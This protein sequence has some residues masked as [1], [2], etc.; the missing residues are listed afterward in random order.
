MK[1]LACLLLLFAPLLSLA[2]PILT[3][4]LAALVERHGD[5]APTRCEQYLSAAI[6]YS[7]NDYIAT[8]RP[9]DL[10]RS[11]YQMVIA[12]DRTVLLVHRENGGTLKLG[13]LQRYPYQ[14]RPWGPQ[15]KKCEFYID[16]APELMVRLSVEA[17]RRPRR[18]S[19]T[20]PMGYAFYRLTRVRGVFTQ[21]DQTW[22]TV[23]RR[24]WVLESSS[25][26]RPQEFQ[27][28]E[29]PR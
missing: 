18:I 10:E 24:D 16:P 12:E 6:A 14:C 21:G 19:G 1:L 27:Y 9:F 23:S 3:L 26:S 2:E 5:Q 8:H 22:E 11:D 7:A 13:Q 25:Q 28:P 20:G 4:R 15:Y 17:S 29:N